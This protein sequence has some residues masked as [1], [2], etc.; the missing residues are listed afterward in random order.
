MAQKIILFTS[1]F[2]FGFGE[3]FL[4]NELQYA[5]MINSTQIILVPSFVKGEQRSLPENVIV[6]TSLA[7]LIH[8]KKVKQKI[9][10]IIQNAPFLINSLFVHQKCSIAAIRKIVSNALLVRIV[11]EWARRYN[12]AR[13]V[14]YTYW[15]D[16]QATGLLLNRNRN[17]LVISRAHRYDLYEERHKPA[18]IPFRS[19][20]LKNID[21]LYLISQDGLRYLTKKYPIYRSKYGLSR[22]GIVGNKISRENI[23][24]SNFF[25]VVSCSF[26]APVKRIHLIANGLISFAIN[27]MDQEIKWNHFGDGRSDDKKAILDILKLKPK[28]LQ[29]NFHGRVSNKEIIEYYKKEFVDVFLNTSS[30]EGIP[31]SI[32]EAISFGIPV[33]GCDV[34]GMREIVINN[35]VLLQREFSNDEFCTALLEVINNESFRNASKR[36]FKERFDANIN[37]GS[38]YNQI[39]NQ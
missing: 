29:I 39:L 28:N 23:R 17:Y 11:F 34:G 14:C 21:N 35:G 2:P 15:F 9:K 27:N 12:L 1:H 16:F 25:N 5:S 31:V 20:S 6:D 13:S 22:L 37:Y 26:I 33:I 30:S 7:E 8:K 10:S 38:F 4:E 19:F 24:N 3:Q 32:M 36:I 18:F